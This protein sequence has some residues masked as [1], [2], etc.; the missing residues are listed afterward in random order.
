MLYDP[1]NVSF[2]VAPSFASLNTTSNN[3]LPLSA[4][5]E[6]SDVIISAIRDTVHTTSVGDVKLLLGWMLSPIDRVK[7]SLVDA[8]S[9]VK[10]I[11]PEKNTIGP[12]LM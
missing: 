5:N 12:T 3:L 9:R 4:C 8:A 7:L 10:Y 11:H 2:N 1:L 6:H